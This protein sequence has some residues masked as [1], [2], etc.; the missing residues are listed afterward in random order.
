MSNFPTQQGELWVRTFGDSPA[1]VIALHGFTL[2]GGMF[3]TLADELGATVAAPDLPGHGR[4]A[5][6]PIT[7][8]SAVAAVAE[9]LTG[10]PIPPVLLGYSQGG[11]VALQ[12]ALSHPHLVAS[13]VLISTGPGMHSTVRKVRRIADDALATR[14]ERI[15]L[16]RFIDEW[17][18]NP[19]TATDSVSPEVRRADR[20][21]RFENTAA[22]LAEALR[23]MGQASVP[24]STRRI[25]LL[26]MSL[27]MIAGER[28]TKYSELA[29]EMA[30][31]RDEDP[32]IVRGAGHNVVLE[33][34]EAVATAVRNLLNP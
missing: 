16:E 12:V 26:P 17:L 14:I 13:L 19:V 33:A 7:M 28:D 1:S 25:S 4:T 29:H 10:M 31:T 2:H 24:D 9:L 27:V 5:I 8:D 23:G 18:A 34:P 3:Q 6:E 22:G 32:V 30:A 11:R 15:G 21:I 20:E